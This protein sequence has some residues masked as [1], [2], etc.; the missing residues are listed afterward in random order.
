MISATL[1][2][3]FADVPPAP[4][5]DSISVDIGDINRD[6]LDDRLIGEPHYQERG[7]AIVISDNNSFLVFSFSGFFPDNET[8]FGHHVGRMPDVT[9]D[10]IAELHV[11]SNLIENGQSQP[12]SYIYS[13]VDGRPLI[14]LVGVGEH[15]DNSLLEN[16]RSDDEGLSLD[17]IHTLADM[18]QYLLQSHSK[19]MLQTFLN[20]AARYQ[21]GGPKIIGSNSKKEDSNTGG[22]WGP[23][24]PAGPPSIGSPPTAY[25]HITLGDQGNGSCGGTFSDLW[26][27]SIGSASFLASPSD[28]PN[29]GPFG[30]FVNKDFVCFPFDGGSCEQP[31]RGVWTTVNPIQFEVGQSYPITV[32]H[33]N[34]CWSNGNPD[35]DYTANIQVVGGSGGEIPPYII[36]DP[37]GLLGQ[38]WDTEPGVNPAAGK[39]AWL[40]L[41]TIDLDIDS[42]N[43]NGFDLP[44]R[45]N[46]EEDIEEK[47][48][49]PLTPGKLIL[50]NTGDIDEDGIPDFADGFGENSAADA[51][52]RF[53]PIVLELSGMPEGDVTFVLSYSDSAPSQITAIQD[54]Y[55]DSVY[56][57]GPG[58]LRLWTKDGNLGRD[59]A[60]LNEGGDLVESG[61]EYSIDQF[62]SG[63]EIILYVEGIQT[64]GTFAQQVIE[65]TVYLDGIVVEQGTDTIRLTVLP[66]VLLAQHSTD[67]VDLDGLKMKP[68]YTDG[69]EAVGQNLAGQLSD[70]D[71]VLRVG[72]NRPNPNSEYD[73][74]VDLE[75][76]RLSVQLEDSAWLDSDLSTTLLTVD[77]NPDDVYDNLS[78]GESSS[79]S[80]DND[81]DWVDPDPS[82]LDPYGFEAEFES[83]LSDKYDSEQPSIEELE[84]EAMELRGL[85]YGGQ[86]DEWF[87]ARSIWRDGNA[88]YVEDS[89]TPE[90]AADAYYTYLK[91]NYDPNNP[92]RP[93]L[94]VIFHYYG[95]LY[96][97]VGLER[98]QVG[99]YL[100]RHWQL[101]DDL[102]TELAGEYYLMPAG[103]LLSG[104]LDMRS[105]TK[106]R[107]SPTR[108]Y[109]IPLKRRNFVRGRWAEHN[110]IVGSLGRPSNSDF[111]TAH[112]QGVGNVRFKPD[113]E[114]QFVTGEIKDWI[115]I[116]RTKQIRAEA[117]HAATHGK[118][119]VLIATTR[120]KRITGPAM[121]LVKGHPDAKLLRCDINSDQYQLWVFNNSD[122]TD[123]SGSWVD[124]Q[125]TTVQQILDG[126]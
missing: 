31:Y 76:F 15:I 116:S 120:T 12:V 22:D 82:D 26:E 118:R 2:L 58:H 36:H 34:T 56:A 90:E 117:A 69:I 57:A 16:D 14:L 83:I 44:D 40:Y 95:D 32:N 86:N 39:T 62:G 122:P 72:S 42:D 24:L 88:I 13:G 112:V 105:A 18:R 97:E 110:I 35:Y 59:S 79:A 99:E 119:F 124:V 100:A 89:L 25:V 78:G 30:G 19:I 4:R 8:E 94:N 65:L 28:Y 107:Y 109:R 37:D 41:P 111:F 1:P 17:Q 7:R 114:T 27:M 115:S 126:Q 84:Q 74:S 51:S 113:I 123:L 63:D 43:T 6:G 48:G 108:Q 96:Q 87:S 66:R 98:E 38:H 102:S 71:R 20:D 64:N 47:Q 54:Q 11:M 70:E 23:A 77:S 55:G 92:N 101:V 60:P 91:D 29:G 10:G 85:L 121:S 106:L 9:G 125:K 73:P 104:F 21:V 50:E 68:L 3:E 33:Q 75:Y 81:D 45:S 103:I 80:G 49:D 67:A 5:D 46:D 53:T 61:T 93:A 52:Q